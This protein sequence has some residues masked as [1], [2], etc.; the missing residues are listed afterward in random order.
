MVDD[1]DGETDLLD[2][3][4]L[5]AA[6]AAAA[7]EMTGSGETDLHIDSTLF[8]LSEA[9]KE[10]QQESARY[11]AENLVKHENE[12]EADAQAQVQVQ[13]QVSHDQEEDSPALQLHDQGQ[14]P[15]NASGSQSQEHVV[16][17]GTGTIHLDDDGIDPALREIV[18]SLTA[19]QVS[20]LEIVVT[21]LLEPTY[22]EQRYRH[23]HRSR[24][25]ADQSP[26]QSVQP[27]TH[28]Q[29][30]SNSQ[31]AAVISAHL[32]GHEHDMQAYSHGT[33][34][35]LAQSSFGASRCRVTHFLGCRLSIN[36]V[37]DRC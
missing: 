26:S 1:G 28:A 7:A 29:G 34:D 16:E 10:A 3:T 36:G 25:R 15:L 32:A 12:H 18:N 35:D 2:A 5:A 21:L 14:V 22:G 23:R 8:A 9:V 20:G 37:G 24:S 4:S 19:Q 6:A 11:A 27:V 31:A 30:L 17:D 33:L 13:V